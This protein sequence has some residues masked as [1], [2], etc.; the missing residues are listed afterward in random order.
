MKQVKQ[1]AKKNQLQGGAMAIAGTV[2]IGVFW[3]LETSSPVMGLVGLL[4][5]AVGIGLVLVF[6]QAVSDP[7]QR[8]ALVAAGDERRQTLDAQ[9]DAL[10]LNIAIWVLFA[11][12]VTA[13]VT[14]FQPVQEAAVFLGLIVVIRWVAF[15][16]L[17][18]RH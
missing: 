6:R 12:L 3:W 16:T 2:M 1:V 4:L 5:L 15:A 11:A 17:L 8:Q 14:G 9:A 13:N 10:A 7:A 18:R